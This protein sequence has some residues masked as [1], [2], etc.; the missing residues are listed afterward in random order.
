MC[1]DN[2][3]YKIRKQNWAF[4]A[5]LEG[6]L[7][8]RAE[9]SRSFNYSKIEKRKQLTWCIFQVFSS[10]TLVYLQSHKTLHIL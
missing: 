5:E 10:E 2:T 1:A 9:G 6:L 3:K 7:F 4:S 8:I